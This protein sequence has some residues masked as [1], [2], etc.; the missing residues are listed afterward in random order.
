MVN[1]S[2][3]VRSEAEEFEEDAIVLLHEEKDQDN[4]GNLCTGKHLDDGQWRELQDL[5]HQYSDVMQS[6]LGRTHLAKHNVER[7]CKASKTTTI[8]LASCLLR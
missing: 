1:T 3:F 2:Y 8:T 7:G 6:K 4:G 5:L